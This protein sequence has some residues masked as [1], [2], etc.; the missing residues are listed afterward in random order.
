VLLAFA[1]Y[2]TL[3]PVN[4]FLALIAMIFGLEDCILA[5]VEVEVEP[6]LS[7]GV[8]AFLKVLNS[9]GGP[10]L[11]TL[12]PLAAR[13]VLV[14]AQASAPVDLSGIEE[15]EK[16]ITADGYKIKLNVVRGTGEISAKGGR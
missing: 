14:N 11:E 8:K 16:T 5:W 7:R 13:E 2:V 1:L 10:P 15:F 6:R 12:P 9:S 4:T 3:K